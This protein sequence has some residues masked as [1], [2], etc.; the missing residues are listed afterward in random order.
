MGD[1]YTFLPKLALNDFCAGIYDHGWLTEGEIVNF[2]SNAPAGP[3]SWR[4]PGTPYSARKA[5]TGFIRAARRA[6]NTPAAKP[7]ITATDSARMM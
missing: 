5:S 1:V 3:L 7:M 2:C 6:G 4:S